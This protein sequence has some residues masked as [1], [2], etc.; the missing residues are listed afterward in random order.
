MRKSY[1][2]NRSS[3]KQCDCDQPSVASSDTRFDADIYEYIKFAEE[4]FA[5]DREVSRIPIVLQ[6]ISAEMTQHVLLSN[7]FSN[8]RI[9]VKQIG[10]VDS[11]TRRIGLG[12]HDMPN[13]SRLHKHGDFDYRTETRSAW[14]QAYVDVSHPKVDSFMKDAVECARDSASAA[15]LAAIFA[16]NIGAAYAIFWPAFK[17]CLAAKVSQTI[18]EET[19]VNLGST[20]ETG[21]WTYHC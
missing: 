4:A 1:S 13:Q 11:S 20:N 8:F 12:T 17:L 3:Q 21:C 15:V 14:V 10:T 6:E 9:E 2:I 7:L 5:N 16:G 19:S 18:S